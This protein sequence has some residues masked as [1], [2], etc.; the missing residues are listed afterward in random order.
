MPR[1]S[2]TLSVNDPLHDY[3]MISRVN[4]TQRAV[5]LISTLIRIRIDA[6]LA[7]VTTERLF[8][9]V[10]KASIEATMTFPAPVHSTLLGLSA[11]FGDRN[12]VGTVQ[13]REQARQTYESGIERGK[14]AV[15]HEEPLRGIHVLSIGHI[16]PGSDV[17]VVGTWAMPVSVIA[18]K[19]LIRVP[20]SVGDV[21]G[22]QP[23]C[24][25]DELVHS[26][27][28]H[29][30]DVEIVCNDG[31][32]LLNGVPAQTV[33]RVELNTPIDVEIL[34][35]APRVLHGVAADGRAVRLDIRACVP[36]N[37]ALDC[38][39]LADASGS[40]GEDVTGRSRRSLRDGGGRLSKHTV[41]IRALLEQA[42]KVESLDKV[43]LW[44]FN[45]SATYLSANTMLD[46]VNKMTEPSFGTEL[47]KSIEQVL[48]VS[49]GRDILLITDGKS[50][51]VDI[52]KISRQGRR[53]HVVLV[54]EDSLE[55]NVGH[56]AAL[57][58]GQLFIVSGAD[59]GPA[60]EAA[61]QA[62]RLPFG[63]NK[64]IRGQPQSAQ[65]I[66]GGVVV[67]ACWGQK[68][69]DTT[70]V[71]GVVMPTMIQG[72]CDNTVPSITKKEIVSQGAEIQS[73]LDETLSRSVAAVAAALAVAYMDE[74]NAVALAEAEGIV[75][76]LTSLVLVDEQ[77]QAQ[78]GIPAHRKI[79][80]TTPRTSQISASGCGQSF[81]I[82]CNSLRSLKVSTNAGSIFLGVESG[83][84]PVW[85]VDKTYQSS[86]KSVLGNQYDD[87]VC[88]MPTILPGTQLSEVHSIKDIGDKLAFVHKN[89]LAQL[90]KQLSEVHSIKDMGNKLEFVH[91]T[92]LAQLGK[93]VDWSSSPQALSRGDLTGVDLELQGFLV[94]ASK[95][96][97][98]IELACAL[99][100]PALAV[101][102]AL[103]ARYQGRGNRSAS[104][105]AHATLSSADSIMVA[106][107][108][109]SLGL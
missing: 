44:Q 64:P 101:A 52:Q 37:L 49:K 1:D 83:A 30:A 100:L 56:M 67:N 54:G 19:A 66:L 70:H 24:D 2:H 105:I 84:K 103:L 65:A 108:S 6:G 10:E 89:K 47:G 82:T 92:R 73:T 43:K 97:E 91:K 42:S 90:G 16:A 76:H 50:Y 34:E 95:A 33:T 59:V 14:S 96:A 99:G 7:T 98:V 40:M 68:L 15:L 94:E 31:T 22:R 53:I 4:G 71:V 75:C 107:A 12:V 13:R 93:L 8:R 104:R 79:A 87:V 69:E 72:P 77:G 74:E 62:M 38:D 81:D 57:T 39:I 86:A 21:Y 85:L 63:S 48:D 109:S 45:D 51:N 23:L 26:S 106:N 58:G 5:P 9:N 46:A 32:A 102:L 29:E 78:E 36:G 27:N 18:G 25:S 55:A 20:V 60:L 11:R 3:S 88:H 35:W 80:T 41:L 17:T 61:F 28:I